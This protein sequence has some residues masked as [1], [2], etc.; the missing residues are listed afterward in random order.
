M[1]KG[2]SLISVIEMFFIQ[3]IRP[4]DFL[5]LIDLIFLFI[6]S[7]SNQVLNQVYFNKKRVKIIILALI[8]LGT[9]I[10]L[11]NY[12][13]GGYSPERLYSLDSSAFVDV[14]GIEGL[15]FYESL[16]EIFPG[17]NEYEKVSLPE[18]Y[19]DRELNKEKNLDKY[20]LVVLQ[21]ESLDKNI[22]DMEYEGK[23]ITPF[24]NKF[25]N[26][27]LYFKNFYSQ[28]VN[29]SHNADFSFLTSFYP[30]SKNYIYNETDMS[31]FETFPQILKDNNYKTLSFVNNKT[32]FHRDKAFPYLGFDEFYGSGDYEIKNDIKLNKK[33]LGINDFDFFRNSQN[34][35]EKTEEPFFSFLI[36][37]TSHGP[38]KYYPNSYSD[39][40]TDINST[41]V[42]DYFR[43]MSF[44]DESIEMFYDYLKEKNLLKDTILVI[45][46]DHTAEI[47]EDIYSSK[48]NFN[49][50]KDIKSPEAVPLFIY[51]PEMK[52]K[53][54]DN[55]GSTVD[56]APTIMDLMGFEEMPKEFLGTSLLKQEKPERPILFL[57]EQPLVLFENQLFEQELDD[58]SKIGYYEDEQKDMELQE[59]EEK[60]ITELIDY[61]N[62]I[63]KS[64]SQ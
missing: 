23:E 17:E 9:H 58:F 43:S 27:S 46:G 6:F 42:R 21:V 64:R 35:I 45:Y 52:S 33:G 22:V 44:V 10:F 36:T 3:I 48:V 15:Y 4:L 50:N 16:K 14:Y 53:E 57:N 28:H 26:E 25:K 18:S 37:S 59:K 1:G 40:Y 29:G 56:I 31:E 39:R 19:L 38:F 12:V 55:P 8:L 34:Y 47:D 62:Y 32:F 49:M 63:F 41:L 7:K 30:V 24:L 60:N 51:H 20:N 61:I 2:E 11:T 5:F 13:L 54:I